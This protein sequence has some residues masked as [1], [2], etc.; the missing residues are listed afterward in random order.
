MTT[1]LLGWINRAKTGTLTASAAAS[2]L[3]A[4][5]VANDQGATSAAWRT[6]AGTTTAHLQ[7]DAGGAVAWRLLSIHRTN[8]TPAATLRWRLS[9]DA[10]FSTALYDSGTLSAQVAA[11]YGQAVHVLTAEVTARYL[12]L[13]I[14]DAT[15]PQGFL[16][17]PLLFAGPAWQ[18]AIQWSADSAEGAVTDLSVPVTRGG[19]EW[20]ELR[21]R[22]RR[23]GVV[24]PWVAREDR[25][26]Q[27]GEF[28][29]AAASGGNILLVPSPAGDLAREPIFGP[30]AIEGVGYA[31]EA[32]YRFRTTRF[33]VT[34]RL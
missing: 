31:G 11:G 14:A 26:P 28:E 3:G 20:P 15:N 2:G 4:D 21:W 1:L 29:R 6:P 10:G 8:L 32:A 33:S 9:G 24:M 23:R 30:A 25:W 34:E 7:I 19:Q 16:S 17:V 12:R 5:Q 27:L 18:P 13:D 22:K